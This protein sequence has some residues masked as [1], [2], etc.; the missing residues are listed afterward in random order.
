MYDFNKY[1]NMDVEKFHDESKFIKDIANTY[2]HYGE[3]GCCENEEVSIGKWVLILIL[4]AIPIVDIIVVICLT[5]SSNKTLKNFGKATLIL[6]V[7]GLILFLMG[8][9]VG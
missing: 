3:Y 8:S 1:K 6:M 2:G 5:F 4:Y 9:C 7:I